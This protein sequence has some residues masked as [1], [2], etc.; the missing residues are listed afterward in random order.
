MYKLFT[1]P[2]LIAL[3]F[4]FRCTP[5]VIKPCNLQHAHRLLDSLFVQYDVTVTDTTNMEAFTDDIG[6]WM[7]TNWDFWSGGGKMKPLYNNHGVHTA[8]EMTGFLLRSYKDS[9]ITHREDQERY[10]RD[11]GDIEC[12]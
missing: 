5:G 1:V 8:D 10:Y 12:K 2:V 7:R 6:M 9:R 3:V 11:M 4:S